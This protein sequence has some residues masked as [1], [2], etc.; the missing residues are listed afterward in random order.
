MRNGLFMIN[1]GG[2]LWEQHKFTSERGAH[3]KYMQ[4]FFFV[5][6]NFLWDKLHD[7][8]DACFDVYSRYIVDMDRDEKVIHSL[9]RICTQTS[10]TRTPNIQHMRL[11]KHL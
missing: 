7:F 5:L 11:L 1:K 9:S 3:N 4:L 10:E 8:I 2:Y 6:K